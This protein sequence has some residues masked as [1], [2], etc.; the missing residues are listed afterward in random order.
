M[1]KN[2]RQ[3]YA[4]KVE[5]GH[6]NTG[7]SWGTGR[8][9]ARVPRVHGGGTQRSGQGAYGNMCRGGHIYAPT[10]SWRRW[11]RKSNINVK[12]YAVAS[13]LAVSAIPSLV[14]SRGHKIDNVP[15]V[16]LVLDDEV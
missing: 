14:M 10:K 12:R 3:A 5:A 2:A 15:E 11:Q 13:A 4:V 16:P 7:D 6:D 9:V 1:A 8:A